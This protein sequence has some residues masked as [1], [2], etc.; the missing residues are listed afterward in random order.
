MLGQ[1]KTEIARSD[2]VIQNFTG[3][4]PETRRCQETETFEIEP[5]VQICTNLQLSAF[6]YY[7]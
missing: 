7:N 2:T 3:N 4:K 5:Y 1:D 6:N